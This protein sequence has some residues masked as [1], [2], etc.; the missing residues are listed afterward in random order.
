MTGRLLTWNTKISPHLLRIIFFLLPGAPGL[1]TAISGYYWFE[2]LVPQ[3]AVDAGFYTPGEDRL[4]DNQVVAAALPWLA[5]G[6]YQLVL[7]HL[8]Q[9][10]YAGHHEGGPQDP[11]WDEAAHRADD[12]IRQIAATLDLTQDTLL[13]VSDHGQIDRGGHG[14]DELVTLTEPFVLAGAG[15]VP[16]RYA[17]IQMVDVAPTLAALLG[18][19]LPASTQGRPLVE[20]LEQTPEQLAALQERSV[21]QQA[22]LLAAYSKAIGEPVK[23]PADGTVATAQR[24]LED[25]RSNRLWQRA[26]AAPPAGR[27]IGLYSP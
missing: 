26:L 1:K 3:D 22:S 12:L 19:N 6:D 24:L 10:D 14:G 9:V 21:A 5:I 23:S 17:D 4:A 7:I 13:V 11:R 25:A 2:K 20:M 15:V 8:D 27:L 18:T 16:G